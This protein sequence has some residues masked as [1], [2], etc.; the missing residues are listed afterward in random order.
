ME[1]TEMGENDRALSRAFEQYLTT[2]EVA[3]ILRLT[4]KTVREIILAGDLVATKFGGSWR[5][6]ESN[7]L[8]FI[9]ECEEDTQD[10]LRQYR[11][12]EISDVGIDKESPDQ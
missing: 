4:P 7:F 11:L 10:L 2:R 8:K 6:K 1:N 3:E 12:G 9:R 5:I